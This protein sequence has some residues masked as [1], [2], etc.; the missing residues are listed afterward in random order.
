MVKV[1]LGTNTSRKTVIAE[2][3]AIIKDILT[4]YNVDYTTS[5]IHLDGVPVTASEMNS[6]FEDLGI[7]DT[8]FLVGIV[9]ADNA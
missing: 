8:C 3:T 7:V 1:T 5:T 2:K 6:S 4:E 9:K